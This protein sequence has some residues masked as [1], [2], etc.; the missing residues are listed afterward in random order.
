MNK[1]EN[2]L[3]G[4]IGAFIA[5]ASTTIA[6]L[7]T[8]PEHFNPLA[9]GGWKRLG[10]VVVVSGGV[11]AALYLKQHPTPWQDVNPGTPITQ[12]RKA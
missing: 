1:L 10:I 7:I 6:L 5:G 3:N 12:V 2:W 11:G 9:V 4:L 8:D